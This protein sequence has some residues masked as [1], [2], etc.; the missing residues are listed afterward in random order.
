MGVGGQRHAPTALPPGKTRY[1][2][3]RR[4]GGLQGRS[5]R[6]WKLS[7]PPTGIR[8][9]DR[10]ARSELLYRLS[11]PGPKF[12]LNFIENNNF[13]KT[14]TQQVAALSPNWSFTYPLCL[15]SI[16]TKIQPATQ[17]SP[18]CTH[19][20]NVQ[21]CLIE[22]IYKTNCQYW[23]MVSRVPHLIPTENQQSFIAPV[24]TLCSRIEHQR[25]RP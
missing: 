1:T 21:R 18:F 3:Y 19:T 13:V 10:P 16:T 6:L 7:P 20:I 25:K 24:H 23:N 15:S 8:S 5:G 14:V 17:V 12:K 9:P 4:L 11:Y 2:L 22:F